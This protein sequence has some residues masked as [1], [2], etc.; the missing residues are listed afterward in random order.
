MTKKAICN[1]KNNLTLHFLNS[2][3]YLKKNAFSNQFNHIINEITDYGAI[4]PTHCLT[5]PTVTSVNQAVTEYLRLENWLKGRN[6]TSQ[7]QPQQLTKKKKTNLTVD[8]LF[9][10]TTQRHWIFSI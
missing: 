6:R 1:T 4:T 9:N 3:S 2:L 5:W 10:E 7:L 8:F